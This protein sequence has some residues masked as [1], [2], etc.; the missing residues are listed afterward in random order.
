[1][2]EERDRIRALVAR[3][4]TQGK[5]H[6]KAYKF[7]VFL[8]VL[9][10]Y[11]YVLLVLAVVIALIALLGWLA[12]SGRGLYV[13]VKIGIPLIILALIIL[14]S[15]WVRLEAPEGQV[16][17][18]KDAK[19]L[20]DTVEA[21]RRALKAPG[22]HQVL[23]TD[24]FNAGVCQ[25]PRLGVFGWQKNYLAVG[26]PMMQALSPD[27]FRAVLAHEFGHL[28]GAHSRFAGWV[29]RLRRTWY[30][31]MEKLETEQRFGTFILK[32]FFQWYA[33][34]FG[35]YSFVLARGNEYEADR[36]SAE[37]VG[38]P[39]AAEGL[40]RGYIMA[41][42]LDNKFWPGIYKRA[43]KEAVPP[44]PPFTMMLQALRETVPPGDGAKSLEQAMAE[45]TG[46]DDTHPS[47]TDRVAALGYVPQTPKH[48]PAAE[49]QTMP[50]AEPPAETA[51]EFFFGA[52]LEE[53]ARRL[54]EDWKKAI[55]EIWRE[56]HEYAQESQKK[57]EELDEKARKEKLTPEET[58]QRANWTADFKGYDAAIPLYRE[59]IAARPASAEANYA[60][61][62]ILLE[63][64]D[65][66]GISHIE[67]AMEEEPDSVLSG[68]QLAYSF[69]RQKGKLEEAEQYRDRAE[70][71]YEL[72]QR[73]YY[74]RGLVQPTDR[75]HRHTLSDE[76]V[77]SL[78][79]QLAEHARVRGAFLVGKAV[80]LLP[81][82]PCHILAI[83][84]RY[85][86]YQM[87]SDDSAA[88][89]VEQFSSELEVPDGTYIIVLN[90][91]NRKLRRALE[92]IEGSQI[93]EK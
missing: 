73:A 38:A 77:E 93:I 63:K 19:R 68:C 87:E 36:C 71:H 14:R 88:K 9:L 23:L 27:Q 24:E 76:A 56:R 2:A 13:I 91:N 58:L 92:K 1:M 7:R 11:A 51:A 5:E 55:E 80:E 6:P 42:S 74:E 45:K 16:L 30:E 8:L 90:R 4:E 85:R 18:P 39:V 21:I 57:L 79:T 37:L 59:I 75:F 54:D 31:L 15:L 10:G 26:L 17:T 83:V 47:I 60:L 40:I 78:R 25:V 48:D 69:L 62:E 29:Y 65:P 43:D 86:W 32:W 53:L 82:K 46:Y 66:T 50:I 12:I 61:G 34:L 3:L 72:L 22:C 49:A 28:S 81:Q 41:R 89:L 52:A 70:R 67:T 20:F 84:P 35:A 64:G 44:D 33:P